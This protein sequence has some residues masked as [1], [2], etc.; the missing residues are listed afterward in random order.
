MNFSATNDNDGGWQQATRR[1]GRRG[2]SKHRSKHSHEEAGMKFA[3]KGRERLADGEV[4]PSSTS[5]TSSAMSPIAANESSIIPPAV[6]DAIEIRI[7]EYAESLKSTVLYKDLCE[8]VIRWLQRLEESD[9]GSKKARVTGTEKSSGRIEQTKQFPES[10]LSTSNPSVLSKSL[11]P[12]EIVAYGLG[13]PSTTFAAQMQLATLFLL[14][15]G[16]AE[17][18]AGG[19]STGNSG[20][21]NA[22]GWLSQPKFGCFC[23]DPAFDSFDRELI[24]RLGI[25]VIERNEECRHSVKGHAGP[26]SVLNT[27]SNFHGKAFGS[28]PSDCTSLFFMVHCSHQMYSNVLSANW[29][30]SDLSHIAIIG[31]S[32]ERYGLGIPM[33]GVS[34]SEDEINRSD[35]VHRILGYVQES[36]LAQ[37]QSQKKAK[38]YQRQSSD[39]V[40][41]RVDA[42]MIYTAFNDTSFI[43]VPEDAVLK[44]EEDGEFAPENAPLATRVLE[45]DEIVACK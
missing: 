19:I 25:K 31:N 30:A 28:S 18:V 40:Y 8:N 5:I 15:Q 13:K 2:K 39:V 32:F 22:N 21:T 6:L 7:R 11:A 43:S 36:P 24:T 41:S 27:S 20:V 42:T 35:C 38:Q 9:D 17:A 33:L 23:Y 26:N 37:T 34:Q 29:N 3:T 14:S 44:M 1:R 4:T 45:K 10:P 12:S 16:N